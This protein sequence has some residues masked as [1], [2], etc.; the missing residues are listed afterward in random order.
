MPDRRTETIKQ[1]AM[2]LI[3]GERID[4]VRIAETCGWKE[5]QPQLT[6]LRGE[7]VSTP[8]P[9]GKT[10]YSGDVHEVSALK[11]WPKEEWLS[12]SL[13]EQLDR[14]CSVLSPRAAQLAELRNDGATI[15]LHCALLAN[16]NHDLSADLQTR[17][18]RLGVALGIEVAV[19]RTRN[20]AP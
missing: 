7:Q 11:L 20:A 3:W 13:E 12:L 5:W 14:W 10:L 6:W 15:T 9:D 2:L 1:M 8:T 4:P 19:S 18:G 16:D 17:I